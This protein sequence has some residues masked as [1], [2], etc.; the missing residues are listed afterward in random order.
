MS[1]QQKPGGLYLDAMKCFENG[2]S[3][4][5][6]YR[7]KYGQSY[8]Q[9]VRHALGRMADMAA[10][11]TMRLVVLESPYAGDVERNL[12]YAAQCVHDCIRRGETPYA[13]HIM[14]TQALDDTDPQER[15]Q[16]IAAGLEWARVCDAVVVYRDLGISSGMAAAIEHHKRHGRVIEYRN[17]L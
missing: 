13:S 2:H 6:R 4:I 1:E 7:E 12:R 3:L 8:R 9:T 5:V 17:I 11:G 10:P 16:G 14:L 15:A